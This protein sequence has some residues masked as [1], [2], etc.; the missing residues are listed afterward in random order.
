MI[1]EGQ[2]VR[3]FEQAVSNHLNLPGGVATSSGTSALYLGLL[4]L[5]VGSG[6]EVILP[7]YVCRSVWDAVRA[8]GAT[9]VLCD[10][11]EDWCVNIETVRPHLTART[12]A[13]V[14]VHT[15]GIMSD[16][17]PI[18]TL[19]PPVIEDCCQAFGAKLDDRRAGTFG[20]LCVLSF[21]ATK[22]LTTGEGGMVLARD[23]GLLLKLRD[24]KQGRSGRWSVRFRHPMTDLQA[25][26]GLSQLNQYRS[27]L[28]RRKFI[29]G[30]YFTQLTGLP[31]RLP[32]SV[33]GR[34][35][36]FRFPLRVHGDFQRFRDSFLANGIQVRQGVDML[37]HRWTEAEANG[38]PG[39]EQCFAETLSIPL[40]PAMNDEECEWVMKSCRHIF[41][42]EGS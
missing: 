17:G 42:A 14:V 4:G 30:Y 18:C 10:V 36:F 2:R 15:F 13:I 29:A 40:Y 35:I 39:A 26:L 7:T 31:I 41:A 6:D 11:G 9:P 34:S 12:K 27:F 5:S 23:H 25:A 21:H 1:A 3:E 28:A 16:V 38:F 32:V 24:L 19:G 22:L 37:L 20:S 33:R 8:T